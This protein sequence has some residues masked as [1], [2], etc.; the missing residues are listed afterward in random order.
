MTPGHENNEDL[1]DET[2]YELA[3]ARDPRT[4]GLR[5][6][7]RNLSRR[8]LLRLTA[9]AGLGAGLGAVL[10]AEAHAAAPGSGDPVPG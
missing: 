5:G 7:S 8:G 2:A 3:R 9:G 6:P 1:T 4:S 10:P